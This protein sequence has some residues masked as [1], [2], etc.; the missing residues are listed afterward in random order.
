MDKNAVK[1]RLEAFFESVKKKYNFNL[2]WFIRYAA[3]GTF[4]VMVEWAVYFV[5]RFFKVYYLT[6]SVISNLASYVV[7]YFISKYWVFRSPHTPHWRDTLL[8]VAC[9]GLNLVAVTVINRFV[10]GTLGMHDVVGKI[11]ANFVAFLIVL[12]FKRY[13]IWTDSENY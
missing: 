13:I 9:N 5:L 7:N 10:V 3:G 2:A 6:A 1:K 4:T 12:V 8:F 11:I